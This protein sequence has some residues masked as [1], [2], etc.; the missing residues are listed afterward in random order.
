MKLGRGHQM[1]ISH[2][3]EI[4]LGMPGANGPL[5]NEDYRACQLPHHLKTILIDDYRLH[6]STID[7]TNCELHRVSFVPHANFLHQQS[8]NGFHAHYQLDDKKDL[9]K[10]TFACVKRAWSRVS[11]ETFAVKVITK[12]RFAHNPK[13]KEMFERELSILQTLRHHNI[14]KLIEYFED[15]STICKRSSAQLRS[16]N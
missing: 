1:R 5:G 9:G 4:S 13:T 14:T 8:G 10:G 15:E 16:F 2:G 6:S 3:D 12:S 11:G 7:L